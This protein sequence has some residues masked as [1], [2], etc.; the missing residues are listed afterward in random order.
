MKICII[1]Y[2][3]SPHMLGGADIYAEKISKEL[4]KESN[5]VIVIT[6]N[7]DKRDFIEKKNNLKIYRFHPLNIFTFYNVC[8]EKK[9]IIEKGIW[10]FLDFYSPYSY[11]KIKDILK[12]EKPDVVH[13]HTPI[14]VTLSAFD[15][16]KSL[17]LPLVFTLHDYLSLCRRAT[18]LHNSGKICTDRNI[19]PICKAYRE[20]SKRIINSKPDIVIGSSKFTLNLHTKNGF[21]RN[22]KKIVEYCGI[23]LDNFDNSGDIKVN[24]KG[25][26]NI[27][28][29]GGLAKHKGVH[30]LIKAFKPIKNKN[31]R[32]HI[33]GG[34]PYE[35][36]LKYLARNDKRIIFYG[37]LPN[38]EIQKYYKSSE[39]LVVP[40]ISYESLGIITQEAFRVGTP[41]IGSRI[42]GIPEIIK[43]NYNGFL[44][45][46][47][48]VNQLKEILENII[49]NPR[50]LKELGKNAKESVKKYEMSK[51]IKKLIEIYKDAIE[52]NKI[53]K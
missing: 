40:S 36:E 42:G 44:F 24:N 8:T 13:I 51:H 1:T 27:L 14:G 11:K 39:F 2:T 28:C 37:K 15:A 35:N 18:L 26:I 20:F 9:S 19:N 45:E 46:A 50:Q 34:G 52:I 29:V 10:A 41:V 32:L 7:P 31:I 25:A 17:K 33:V 3:Y 6:I 49:E 23:K 53:R 5:N 21:F 48:N 12:K 4:A 38:E 16:V 47:G 43:D 22:S 30:I